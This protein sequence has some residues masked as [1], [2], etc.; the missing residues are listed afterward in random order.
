M[1]GDADISAASPSSSRHGDALT[2]KGPIDP[3]VSSGRRKDN[4]TLSLKVLALFAL[5]V[6]LFKAESEQEMLSAISLTHRQLLSAKHGCRFMSVAE[7][8]DLQDSG[9]PVFHVNVL[10]GGSSFAMME[11][12]DM[13]S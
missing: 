6:E 2:L 1:I 13:N 7:D 3:F 5:Q 9:G 4:L 8:L 10:R 12:T 11:T